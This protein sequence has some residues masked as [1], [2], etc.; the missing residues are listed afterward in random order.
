LDLLGN[1]HFRQHANNACPTSSNA[2]RA[3]DG[4]RFI[5]QGNTTRSTDI[6]GG[7]WPGSAKRIDFT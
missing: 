5:I 2:S 1:I 6:A 4:D 3:F 7:R